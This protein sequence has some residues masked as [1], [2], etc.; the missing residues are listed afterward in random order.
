M[1]YYSI[2]DIQNAFLTGVIATLVALVI[3]ISVAYRVYQDDKLEEE[4]NKY[5]DYD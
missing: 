3:G 2:H 5:Q 4:R 1:Y